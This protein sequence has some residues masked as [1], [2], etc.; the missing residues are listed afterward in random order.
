MRGEVKKNEGGGCVDHQTS[1]DNEELGQRRMVL[2]TSR[3]KVAEAWKFECWRITI[4]A[5]Q[6]RDLM[7]LTVVI[8]VSESIDST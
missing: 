1:F 2:A 3:S 7:W 5:E 8:Q 6:Q 4:V